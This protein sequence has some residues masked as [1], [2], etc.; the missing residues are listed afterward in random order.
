MRWVPGPVLLGLVLGA[1]AAGGDDGAASPSDGAAAHEGAAGPEAASSSAESGHAAGN[2]GGKGLPPMEVT[3][4]ATDTI[5][6][7][8]EGPTLQ[9]LPDRISAT[10]GTLVLLRYSNGGELPHNLAL[11]RRDDAIDRSVGEA[12]EAEATGYIPVSA[13]D[14][15]IAYTPLVSPGQTV[16]ME[17][18]VPDPGEYTFICL[19]PGHAQMMLGTLTARR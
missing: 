1:C 13:V 8:S 4:N 17:F 11:F 6:L 18:V 19:F 12:Y 16:E 5:Y 15:L 14:D 2:V 9:F 3:G 10:S 7:T